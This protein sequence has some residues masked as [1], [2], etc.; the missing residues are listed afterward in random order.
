MRRSATRC[1]G[2]QPEARGP[3]RQDSD[4]QLSEVWEAWMLSCNSISKR[5]RS[6]PVASTS[7]KTLRLAAPAAALSPLETGS[8]LSWMALQQRPTHC[9]APARLLT[10]AS[11]KARKKKVDLDVV[12]PPPVARDSVF[13]VFPGRNTPE[14]R[15]FGHRRKSQAAPHHGG[16]RG[17]GLGLD[18]SLELSYAWRRVSVRV[19]RRVEE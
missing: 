17:E 14:A 5:P 15:L 2:A 16:R 18:R 19:A 8:M 1:R 11:W 9:C 12:G 13:I 10:P 3:A 4:L 7:R 6:S